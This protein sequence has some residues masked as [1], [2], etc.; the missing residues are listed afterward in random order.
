MIRIAREQE[1]GPGRLIVADHGF[2]IGDPTQWRLKKDMAGGG[3]MMDIG[4]Y[5]CTRRAT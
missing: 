2:S 3:S 5:A 1:F 4:I